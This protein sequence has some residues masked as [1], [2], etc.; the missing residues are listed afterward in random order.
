MGHTRPTRAGAPP[1]PQ[2][3]GSVKPPWK[4]QKPHSL[5]W[6]MKELQGIFW[7]RSGDEGGE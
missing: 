7:G 6:D 2:G 1:P 3:L 5:Q 4:G